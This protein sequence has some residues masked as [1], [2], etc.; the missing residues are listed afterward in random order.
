MNCYTLIR[1]DGVKLDDILAGLEKNDQS[2]ENVQF[3]YEQEISYTLTNEVQRNSGQM[4]FSKPEY[5]YFKQD[6]PLE[7]IIVSNG[8]KVWI[9]TPSY[10]QVI[11]D[12]WSRWINSGV[13][14]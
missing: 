12:A 8:K 5:F 3:T 13:L 14:A 6:K 9:Y 2:M 1:A 11:V 10:K 4:I 7:Q